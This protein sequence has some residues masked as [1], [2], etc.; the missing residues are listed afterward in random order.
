MHVNRVAYVQRNKL[1]GTAVHFSFLTG[2]GKR[3]VVLK[4]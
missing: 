3:L 1:A 4:L 2:R